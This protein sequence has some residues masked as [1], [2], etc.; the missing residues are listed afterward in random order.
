[1]K[2]TKVLLMMLAFCFVASQALAF[3]IKPESEGGGKI[4]YSS[5][6]SGSQVQVQGTDTLYDAFCLQ[7]KVD[8]WNSYDQNGEL[9]YLYTVDAVG[10]ITL[11]DETKWLYAAY[12][13]QE[14]NLFEDVNYNSIS[15]ID[16]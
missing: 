9:N 16:S 5:N 2:K 12:K 8:I 11:A 4:I 14:T 1:M 6:N 7:P 10:G 13:D 15:G 3:P